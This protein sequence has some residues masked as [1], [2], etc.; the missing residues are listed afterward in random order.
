M[1]N[2]DKI[3]L[4]SPLGLYFLFLLVVLGWL[5][6]GT[7]SLSLEVLKTLLWSTDVTRGLLPSLCCLQSVKC[8]NYLVL[9]H[10]R[11]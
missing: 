3:S 1:N 6:H 11:A 2:Y 7:I 5:C 9:H 10:G 4:I 8:L